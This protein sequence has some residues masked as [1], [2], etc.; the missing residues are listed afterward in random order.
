MEIVNFLS[1]QFWGLVGKTNEKI[2]HTRT[3]PN[4]VNEHVGVRYI[5]DDRWEHTMDVYYPD[6]RTLSNPVIID[7]HGGGWM[8]GNNVFNKRFCYSLAQLGFVVVNINYRLIPSTDIAGQLQD[9]IS[10]IKWVNENIHYF[11]GDNKNMFIIGDSAGGFLAS[12]ATLMCSSKE[13]CQKFNIIKP[14]VKI[15]GLALISPVCYMNLKGRLQPYYDNLLKDYV[16]NGGDINLLNIDNVIDMG[17][18][19]PTLLTTSTGDILARKTTD[20]LHMLLKE[21]RIS[22]QYYCWKLYKG[23]R[24]PHVFPIMYPTSGPGKVIISYIN[25]FFKSKVKNPTHPTE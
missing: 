13:L 24:L 17:K 3:Y 6:N 2:L 16:K 15:N 18:M 1:K 11:T 14:D 21:K 9:C 19:P 25:E 20:K 10:A 7:I 12:Y 5:D 23:M 8:S 4:D 22:N